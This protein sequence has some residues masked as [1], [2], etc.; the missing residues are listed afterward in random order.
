MT[1]NALSAPQFSAEDEREELAQLSD[2]DRQQIQRDLFGHSD[3]DDGSSGVSVDASAIETCIAEFSESE[4]RDYESALSADLVASESNAALFFL[5][6]SGTHQDKVSPDSHPWLARGGSQCIHQE[7]ARRL[8]R[9]WQFRKKL[10][11]DA[12]L[13]R[14]ISELMEP[15]EVTLRQSLFAPTQLDET[16]RIVLY[17][18]RSRMDLSM[19]T[20]ESLVSL[21]R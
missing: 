1:N 6:C 3:S 15:D 10:F 9:Y 14:P 19:Y 5:R 12:G 8:L 20:R 7:A 2:A 21:L 13:Q 4:R 11:G 18:H 17:M 16:G